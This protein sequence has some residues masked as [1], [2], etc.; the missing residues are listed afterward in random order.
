M[1]RLLDTAELKMGHGSIIISS[2]SFGFFS[3]GS[4]SD[5]KLPQ[6]GKDI[7]LLKQGT[8][9]SSVACTATRYFSLASATSA[10]TSIQTICSPHNATLQAQP[11][12]LLQHTKKLPTKCRRM[13]R[14][15][16]AHHCHSMPTTGSVSSRSS[17]ELL[18]ANDRMQISRLLFG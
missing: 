3:T 5:S 2:L 15:T 1:C 4:C 9:N 13:P 11:E 7:A 18:R 16:E 8:W 14:S 17:T 6:T 12:L 10:F